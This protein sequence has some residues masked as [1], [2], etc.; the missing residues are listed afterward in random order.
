MGAVCTTCGGSVTLVGI[1]WVESWAGVD[2]ADGNIYNLTFLEDNL[3]C[4]NAGFQAGRKHH[5]IIVV[6]Q[7]IVIY[8][9]HDFFFASLSLWRRLTSLLLPQQIDGAQYCR[10]SVVVLTVLYCAS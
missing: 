4:E 3:R 9:T 10:K 5:D 8:P 1:W 7:K 6:L 2:L